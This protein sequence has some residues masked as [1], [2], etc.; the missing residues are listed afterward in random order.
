MKQR[1]REPPTAVRLASPLFTIAGFWLSSSFRSIAEFFAALL[2]IIGLG[3]RAAPM[4][5]AAEPC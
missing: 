3:T 5:A 2:V 1:S 4:R